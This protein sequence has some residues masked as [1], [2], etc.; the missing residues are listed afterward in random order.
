MD[1]NK[2][3]IICIY[4]NNKYREYLVYNLVY[5]YIHTAKIKFGAVIGNAYPYYEYI[6]DNIYIKYEEKIMDNYLKNLQNIY[7]KC[8]GIMDS[9]ILIVDSNMIDLNT[10][11][12][13]H[14]LENYQIYKINIIII[15]DKIMDYNMKKLNEYTN[16]V[17]VMKHVFNKYEYLERLYSTFFKYDY[18]KDEFIDAYVKCTDNLSDIMIYNKIRND[19][20]RYTINL[21]LPKVVFY[22]YK[23]Y[24]QN[25][26]YKQRCVISDIINV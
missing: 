19:I 1:V 6:S 12:W 2:S 21:S 14:I 25:K 24:E 20:C 3:N 7:K 23:I 8:N 18:D 17:F 10:E 11:C 16:V 13:E 22:T 15:L 4:G 5:E 9:N 26:I